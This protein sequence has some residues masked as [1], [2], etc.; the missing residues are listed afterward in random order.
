M[1]LKSIL[2]TSTIVLLNTGLIF[3]LLG[4]ASLRVKDRMKPLALPDYLVQDERLGWKAK[5]LFAFDGEA[6]DAA[7]VSRQI[8]VRTDAHGFRAFGDTNSVHCKV[9]FI[10]DSFTL[11]RDVSDSETYFELLRQQLG[12]EVFAYG[13]EGFNT[14]QEY[15][16]LDE[17]IDKI[18]PNVVVL[19]LCRNDF[20]GNT[21]ALTKKSCKNQCHVS[22][23][24]MQPGGDI[25]YINP[26]EGAWAGALNWLP[27]RL[28]ASVAYRLDNRNSIP[29]EANTVEVTIEAQ[30][31]SHPLF[32]DSVKTTT[33]L[34]E[35][36][37]KRCGEVPL[38]AFDTTMI[39]PYHT[40]FQAICNE[41]EIS[42]VPE[43][44]GSVQGAFENGEAVYA[45]DRYHWNQVGHAYC[46]KALAPRI[47]TLCETR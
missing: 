44:P 8:S 7:G 15:L 46:A 33:R 4:E 21:L 12:I 3:F 25:A 38:L 14:L 11:A 6:K 17:W 45:E 9:L 37:K 29:T 36:F 42:I 10:G 1:H 35:K 22:Q 31:S 26:G 16:V 24:F 43:V 41:L 34:L 20:I 47:G 2:K 40:A 27:S 28:L 39:E 19:Q 23:P 32:A 18:Q 30:G 5:P 13:A